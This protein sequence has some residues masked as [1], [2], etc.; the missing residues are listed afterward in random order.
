VYRIFFHY[1]S[2]A[3]RKLAAE[4]ESYVTTNSQSASLSWNKAPIWSLRPD[5]YY[6][7]TVAGLLIWGAISDERTGRFFSFLIYIQSVGFLGRKISPSQGRYLHTEQ[8]KHIINVHRYPCLHWDST[9]I[10]VF[11][12]AKMVHGLVS[13]AT[14]I[15]V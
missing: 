13:A 8:H 15:C 2:T 9:T 3:L 7:L 10:P 11:E 6:C 14:V 4:S 5:F 1:G 12:L